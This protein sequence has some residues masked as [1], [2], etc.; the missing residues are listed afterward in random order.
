MFDH[1]IHTIVVSIGV[2]NPHY[3]IENLMFLVYFYIYTLKF[4]TVNLIT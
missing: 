3:F 1:F 4:T 2:L